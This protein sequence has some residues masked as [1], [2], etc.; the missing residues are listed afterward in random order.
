MWVNNEVGTLKEAAMFGPPSIETYLTQFYPPEISLCFG[1]FDVIEAQKEFNG[2]VNLL[3][4]LGVVVLDMKSAYVNTLNPP[5][6]SAEKL[7]L[8]LVD[9]VLEFPDH[10]GEPNPGTLL[11]LLHL[12][13]LLYGEEKAVALN[14]SLSLDPELP[15]G[16][17]FFARDQAN[18]M[19]DTCFLSN[20][21][22]PI[23]QPEVAVIKAALEE[24]GYH[25]F[26]EISPGNFEGGDGMIIDGDIY[27]GSGMRTTHEG[28]IQIANHFSDKTTYKIAIPDMGSWEKNMEVM[29]SDTFFM[30]VHHKKIFG[31]IPVL[32]QC[33]VINMQTGKEIPYLD[34]FV[35]KGYSINGIPTEEQ[36]NYAANM[37]VT[38]PG[39]L[40]V[41][42]DYNHKTNGKLHSDLI[43]LYSAKLE[44]LTQ[45][46]GATHCM[47]LQTIKE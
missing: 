5:T 31:C 32:E 14:K 11:H 16:N 4:Q 10:T 3:G 19:F 26:V 18:V 9:K 35:D 21:K 22:Y 23:R 46:V 44:H 36:K 1:H 8:D 27:V 37:L 47:I 45:A 33:S 20:M 6:H 24:L 17:I 7:V 30:P 40:I 29:H 39:V 13:S 12:D 15:L 28:V 34:H 38:K 2:L 41:P 42:S 43:T 25:K